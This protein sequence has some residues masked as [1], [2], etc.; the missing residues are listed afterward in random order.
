MKYFRITN[1]TTREDHY[2]S[3]DLPNESPAHVMLSAHLDPK[4]KYAIAEVTVKEF[5]G[6]PPRCIDIDLDVDDRKDY[7]DDDFYFD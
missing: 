2:V 5:Y 7:F 4:F 1:L 3:S 6:F